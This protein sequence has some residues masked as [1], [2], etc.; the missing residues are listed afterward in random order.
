MKG[1]LELSGSEPLVLEPDDPLIIFG[2]KY[3]LVGLQ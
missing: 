2:S 1:P 3:F